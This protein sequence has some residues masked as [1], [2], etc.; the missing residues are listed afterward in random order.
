MALYFDKICKGCLVIAT[1]N[2]ACE[3][4]NEF[5]GVL[6][7]SIDL[8]DNIEWDLPI[9]NGVISGKLIEWYKEYLNL[10]GKSDFNEFI[11]NLNS[12]FLITRNHRWNSIADIWEEWFYKIGDREEGSRYFDVVDNV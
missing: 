10:D 12:F 9:R 11:E 4:I 8:P 1:C 5:L 7:Q 3:K 6:I 2:E